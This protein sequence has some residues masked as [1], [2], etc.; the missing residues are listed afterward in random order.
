[1][2]LG[3]SLDTKSIYKNLLH[4]Y[5]LYLQKQLVKILDTTLLTIALETV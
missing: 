2:N 5:I 3:R 1:M 4:F